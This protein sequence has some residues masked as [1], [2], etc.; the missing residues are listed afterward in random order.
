M[1]VEP[2]GEVVG[3][4]DAG[5]NGVHRAY[6]GSVGGDEAARVREQ[7]DQRDLAHEG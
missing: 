1:K 6:P 7:R 2:R 4:A 5:E 3:S